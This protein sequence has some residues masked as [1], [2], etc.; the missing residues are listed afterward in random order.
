MSSDHPWAH[1]CQWPISSLL[2]N[3]GSHLDPQS[4]SLPL[5]FFHVAGG[6]SPRDYPSFFVQSVSTS[7]DLLPPP[8]N[9]QELDLTTPLTHA[10]K[11]LF[12]SEEGSD[13]DEGDV[14]PTPC[15][16]STKGRVALPPIL[17][18]LSSPTTLNFNTTVGDPCRTN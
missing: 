16:Y 17:S 2:E 9:L 10:C 14:P 12:H 1:L 6:D 3:E 7:P 5:M 18:L 15:H 13:N 8:S 4:F 11:F